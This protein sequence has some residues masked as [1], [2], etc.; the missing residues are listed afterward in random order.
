MIA[1]EYKVAGMENRV[2]S[3]SVRKI[4]IWICFILT[5]WAASV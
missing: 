1:H 3:F 5:D 4:L 2:Y